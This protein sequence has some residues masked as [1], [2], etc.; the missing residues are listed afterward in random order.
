MENSIESL[1]KSN[2]ADDLNRLFRFNGT[3]YKRW[4][5]KTFFYLTLLNVAYILVEKCPKKKDT[6][7]MTDEEKAEHE[8]TVKKWEKDHN[9]CRNYLL[10]CLS[11]NLYDYYDQAHSSAKKIWKSLQQKYD[12]E[13]AGSKKYACSH[14]FRFQ[15][16]EIKFV[17][18]Q[19]HDLQM[20]AN[21]VRHEGIKVDEQMEF[22]AIID[23]LLDSWKEFGKV[24]RHKQKK[25]FIESLIMP[26]RV[27]EEHRKQD[28]SLD[29]NGT[30]SKVNLLTS[31][32]NMPRTSNKKLKVKKNYNKK[33]SYKGQFNQRKN[34]GPPSEKAPNNKRND[35]CYVCGKPGHI[36]RLCN[37]RK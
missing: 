1:P 33:K 29:F 8:T 32:D 31:N 4:K 36:A 16:V 26:L 21:D 2:Q 25:L 27:E 10:N 18:E 6:E 35:G 14:Y 15:M 20:L 3:N 5:Q 23:K 17:T 30:V 9:Y 28:N 12:T 7:D 19:A 13:E 34:Q 22:A 11:D 37:F 24:L